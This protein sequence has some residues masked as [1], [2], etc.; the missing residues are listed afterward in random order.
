M[1]YIV[2]LKNITT[3]EEL[4]NCLQKTLEL[5][6]YY[7]KNLDALNDVLTDWNDE[8]KIIFINY[9]DAQREF[10]TYMERLRTLCDELMAEYPNLHIDFK[11]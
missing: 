4:H 5:P 9:Q 6:D 8:V 3:I 2:D 11:L 1:E 10:G 7:G